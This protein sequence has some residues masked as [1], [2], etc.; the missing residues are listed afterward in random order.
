MLPKFNKPTFSI[1]V[2]SFKKTM[3]FRQYLV[4]E[5]KILLVAQQSDSDSDIIRALTQIIS[6]C[7]MEDLDVAKLTTFD[8]EYIYLKLRAKS[9]NNIVEL[10]YIDTQDEKEYSFNVD[11]DEVDLTYNPEHTNIIN[12]TDTGGIVM[13]YPHTGI[14]DNLPENISA[15]DL[16]DHMILS[17]IDKVFDED[18]TYSFKDETPEEQKDFLNHLDLATYTKFKDFFDTMPRLHMELTYTNSLGTNRKITLSS[19]R[20]FFTW[21]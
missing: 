16:M 21:G 6:N 2:P 8:L 7:A 20:D 1:L 13:C 12:I 9:V 3:V 18:S 11:L 17:C 5:E 15:V 10:K 14:T 4:L 19:L